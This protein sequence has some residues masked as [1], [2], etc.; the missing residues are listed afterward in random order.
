[1]VTILSEKGI[2]TP[3]VHTR[4]R[5]PLARME[6]ADDVDGA[7]KASPLFAKYGAKTDR[8][9]A[10]ELLVARMEQGPGRSRRRTS[11]PPPAPRRR[12]EPAERGDPLT[13]FLG[14]AHEKAPAG[15]RS[16]HVRHAAKAAVAEDRAARGA[17]PNAWR[18]CPTRSS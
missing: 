6:P 3:V 2:P 14:S 17:K 11:R 10:R 12:A 1:M 13:D 7:A 15:G 18:T 5:G 16:R 9:S 8:E 4:L